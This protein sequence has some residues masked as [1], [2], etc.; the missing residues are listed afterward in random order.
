M[1]ILIT[2]EYFA[3]DL[4]GGAEN[5]VLELARRLSL[6]RFDITVLTTGNPKV[7]EFDGIPTI[8]LPVHRYLMNL[9]VPWIYK[10]AK[11]ADLIQTNNYN[12]CFPSLIAG[13]M[14]GIPVVCIIHALWR[15]KWL[16]MR[17]FIKGNVSRFV[18]RFQLLHGYNRF[19]FLSD[20][21]RNEGLKLGI[22]E[23]LTQV[24]PPGMRY[25][26][27]RV[28]TKENFILFVGRLAKQKGLDYL[29]QAAKEL[30]SIEFK[31]VGTGEEEE[32]IKS[33]IPK[34]VELLGYVSHERLLDL[35]ARAPIFCLP[36]ISE[37]FGLV[38]IEAMASGCAIV[39]TVPLD[40]EGRKIDIRNVEQL[41]EAIRYLFD[42]RNVCL[43]MGEI[44]R[45]KAKDYNWDDFVDSMVE[46][47]KEVL[48]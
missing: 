33:C 8:R 34:N 1:K 44:N 40:Y 14:L 32:R 26:E 13:K 16:E 5:V 23:Q 20:F 41:R 22:P 30:P 29:I 27:Y 17:G 18:E 24:V 39:S 48:K 9:A 11:G 10:H 25:E 46:V 15:D 38:I 3:P 21:S 28:A 2:N 19:I 36:S 43:K 45:N 37:T 35:Y 7:K 4:Y 6:R 31:I 12:A 42:N 47:Y